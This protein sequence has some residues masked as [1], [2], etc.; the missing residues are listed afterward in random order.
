MKKNKL[1]HALDLELQSVEI[2][3]SNTLKETPIQSKSQYEA[4]DKTQYQVNNKKIT[5]NTSKKWKIFAPICLILALA[6]VLMCVIIPKNEV[7][8]SS[9][10][11]YII[12][13][14]PSVCVTTNNQNIIVSA[15]SLNAD[16]DTILSDETLESFS[17][18]SIREFVQKLIEVTIEKNFLSPAYDGTIKLYAIN[19]KESFAREKCEYVY[20]FFK[21]IL[22]EQNITANIQKDVMK[23]D[24]FKNKLNLDNDFHDLDKM[25][26]ELINHDKFFDPKPEF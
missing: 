11:S 4:Q 26:E 16:G 19:N 9:L 10:T 7:S 12:E 8:A 5:K 18:L 2:K 21:E 22:A 25:E 15:I 20:N 3:M 13:I 6:V 24:E 1:K 23:I 14:N 17:N